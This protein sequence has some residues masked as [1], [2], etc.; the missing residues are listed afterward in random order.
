MDIPT[1][2][3]SIVVLFDEAFKY[4]NGVKFLS[5][6]RANAAPVCV[7]QLCKLYNFHLK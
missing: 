6:A 1:S 3:T 5:Y 7:S 2:F 4:G